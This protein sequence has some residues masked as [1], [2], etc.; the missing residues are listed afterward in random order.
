MGAL[1][2]RHYPTK[3]F[4]KAADH[5]Y[6]E[7][8]AGAKGWACWGGKTGGTFLRAATGS[9]RR[10][11]AIAEPDEKAGITCYLVNGVC[12]QAANRILTPAAITV[13][14]AR[15]YSLSVAIFGVYGRPRAMLGLCKAP[16]DRHTG[17]TGDLTECMGGAGPDAEQGGPTTAGD[18]D[19]MDDDYMREVRRLHDRA[20]S[21][22]FI[23]VNGLFQLQMQQF[24][25]LM[26]HK[27]GPAS[28]RINVTKYARVMAAREQ[29]EHKR[30]R[31]EERLSSTRNGMAFVKELDELT[32]EF[33]SDVAGVLEPK[34]YETLFNLRPDEKIVL[35]DPDIVERVYGADRD[36][37]GAAS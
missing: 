13:D 15:G 30:L 16:F 35:S 1:V 17:V 12:H 21:D 37:P 7:C 23:D 24:K 20:E 11:G 25:L 2:V 6:V 22:E 34:A 8:G 28:S 3:L 4:L 5:T 36:F 19:F 29:F 9:T 33:Q 27:F 32:L 10:A 31:V 14:G 26:T 18:P